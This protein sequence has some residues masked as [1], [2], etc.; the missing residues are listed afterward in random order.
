MF[1]LITIGDATVDLF[2]MLE[3]A[4]VQCDL[5]KD[6]CKL[7]LDYGDKIPIKTSAQE[8]GGNAANVAVGCEKLGLSTAIITD[9]GDD[10]QGEFIRDELAHAGV[11]TS[12]ARVHK[13]T[14]SCYS[15]ILTYKAERTALSYH[16]VRAYRL[17]KLPKTPWT[18]YTSMGVG[19][20]P[21]QDALATYLKKNPDIRLAMNPG[22]Y[23]CR[24]GKEKI[25]ELFH[26]TDVLF[27]NTREA[28][29]F[30]G[31]SKSIP[32]L[33]KRFHALGVATV[34][35]TDGD[36]GAYA[37]D[38]KECLFMGVY[39][40]TPL[41]KTGVGDAFSSG[42]LSAITHKKNMAKAMQRGTANAAGVIQHIGAQAGQLTKREIEKMAR[43]FPRIKPR[44]I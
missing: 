27:V 17:P 8:I 24:K 15:V 5:H 35:I 42:F 23:Q 11:N 2:V 20:E 29:C 36:R 21:L 41:S 13:K 38:G 30:V 22:S 32:A 14:E 6:H 39:P 18:Y 4:S 25:K 19:F 43:R 31:K 37:S 16:S 7:I 12:M 44:K 9:V 10:L 40:I 3:D 28:E 34:V 26:R 33:C 1:D